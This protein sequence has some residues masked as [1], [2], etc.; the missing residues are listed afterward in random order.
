MTRGV[1]RSLSFAVLL[2]AVC[3]SRAGAQSGDR[4]LGPVNP[5]QV[6]ALEG[7][8]PSWAQPQADVGAVPAEL[9]L[10]QLTLVL[11]RSPQ[12]QQA[13]EQFLRNQQNPA[14]SDYH[15]WL[16]PREVGERFGVSR[17][18][19]AAITEWLRSQNLQ[20]DSVAESRV[21]INFS[22]A[23]AAVGNAFGGE[24][25]YFLMNGKKRISLTAPPRIPAALAPVIQAIHGLYTVETRPM[26]KSTVHHFAANGAKP[27]LTLA[28][29]ENF[30]V[31]G[32]FAVIYDV[33]ANVTGA[34][35]TIA[36]IGRSRVF[37]ADVENFQG[38]FGLPIQEP[39]VIIPPDGIDPGP[40]QAFPPGNGI[41][42]SD[43]AE[44]TVDVSRAG[45]IAPGATL[46]LVISASSFTTDGIAIAASYAVDTTPLLAHIMSLSFGDCEGNQGQAGVA[47][48]D[49]LFSQAAAEG[50][51]V[52]V[53]SGDSGAAGCDIA[54]QTPPAAQVLNTNYICSSSYATCVGGTEF[55]DAN[56]SLYWGATNP[57]T[58]ASAL[59]YIPEGAWNEPTTTDPNEPFQVASSGGGV[60][61]YVPTPFWQTGPGVPATRAGRYTPDLA[62]SSAEHD[63]YVGCFTAGGGDCIEFFLVF[64]G[65][66]TAAQ[67]MAGIAALLNQKLGIPQGN[68]NPNLYNIAATTN[69]IFHDVTIA[70]SGVS[71]CDLTGNTPSMCDNSTPA[72]LT[73][74]GGLAGYVVGPGYDEA[75]GLGSLDVGNF[76][77]GWTT[78]GVNISSTAT[79]IAAS[80]NPVVVGATV[81]L[82][83]AVTTTGP[84]PPT[85]NVAFL[86]ASTTLGTVTLNPS[87]VVTF[88]TSSLSLGQH[89]IT[90][91]YAGDNNN[92]GS[93]SPAL[94]QTILAGNPVP[95]LISLTPS[96]ASAGGGTFVL[97]LTGSNFI[98]DSQVLWNGKNRATTYV[99][100]GTQLQASITAADLATAGSATVSVSNPT[101]SGGTSNPETFDVLET[102]A[103]SGGY[104]S[105]F[106][107]GTNLGNSAM[108]QRNGLIGVGTTSPGALLD[109]EFA[110]AAPSN[111]LL[112]NITYNN[113][114]AVTN[115]VVS[116][117][118]MNFMDNSTAANLSKQ[119]ARIAYIRE[120]G[121]TGGVTAFD[122]ALTATEVVNSNAP[123]PVRSINIE[124]PSMA[125]GTSLS[126]FTGLYIGSP[127]GS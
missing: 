108:F 104:L 53:A 120:A 20:V 42:S 109:V 84:N 87:G 15:H 30:V 119:T 48:W 97:T 69:N 60:S 126:F 101:P 95:M 116:A 23:A 67:D 86:D 106:V 94:S 80:A 8:H 125:T 61:A 75:T 14:S 68:L 118:D 103:G 96:S 81:T 18:D 83:A 113:S 22:G 90:A 107:N 35:Q 52:F 33:P 70:S 56:Y 74:T 38:L 36:I 89:S 7:H 76:L 58:A 62:F 41:L 50:I 65:T 91:V 85:G 117:F 55:A 98:P 27:S 102:F 127:S 12:E 47:F 13:F 21:R 34:N 2:L 93:T 11:A 26:V 3:A 16:T 37:N 45:S 110:T 92:P 100:G 57:I 5:I 49:N 39:T 25:H 82:T 77:A 78:T 124:G 46:D 121:A 24:M 28:P 71:P 72:P 115:A 54:F 63:G 44:A 73:L 105:M 123:F 10:Q 17:H 99:S 88:T 19:L 4:V 51:S 1:G 59:S 114:T 43:Q 112:S 122:T 31:P 66:S 64:F 29:G 79:T 9:R 6:V 111:A 40:P 32:D